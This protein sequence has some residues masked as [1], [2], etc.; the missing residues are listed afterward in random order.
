MEMSSRATHWQDQF[1]KHA[2]YA[3][4]ASADTGST[5]RTAATWRRVC[6]AGGW[7]PASTGRSPGSCSRNWG[8]KTF[9]SEVLST[10]WGRLLATDAL[11]MWDAERDDWLLPPAEADRLHQTRRT[12]R[13]TQRADQEAHR[14]D[15]EAQVR[16]ELGQEVARLRAQL[17]GNLGREDF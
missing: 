13:E 4:R 2:L 10:R 9:Y 6:R 15:R 3:E 12:E 5:T 1:H 17:T 14:A 16:A 11:H 8:A 7:R